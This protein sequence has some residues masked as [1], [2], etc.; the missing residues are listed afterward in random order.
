MHGFHRRRQKRIKE[1][2]SRGLRH[3]R[4]SDPLPRGDSPKFSENT[5]SERKEDEGRRT[6]ATTKWR[7]HFFQIFFY[8]F[9]RRLSGSVVMPQLRRRQ[10]LLSKPSKLR[11]F[12]SLRFLTFFFSPASPARTFCSLGPSQATDTSTSPPP[13]PLPFS[14]FDSAAYLGPPRFRRSVCAASL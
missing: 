5:E 1:K 2:E 6:A 8:F 10:A 3:P 4:P 12:K 13:S 14:T 11:L 7:E 9:P